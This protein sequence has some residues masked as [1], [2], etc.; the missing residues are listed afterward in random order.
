MTFD[1][2]SCEMV[3]SPSAAATVPDTSSGSVIDARSTK[4]I[5][6]GLESSK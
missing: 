4:Q 3:A 2:G 5:P 6:C 1:N